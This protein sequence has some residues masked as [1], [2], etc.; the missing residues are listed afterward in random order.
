MKT[1]NSL[2]LAVI[3]GLFVT[4]CGSDDKGPDKTESTKT[5][6][7]V[8]RIP[9]QGIA[10][11]VISTPDTLYL[12][13]IMG[14]DNAPNFIS[15]EFQN[16]KSYLK[17]EGL[18]KAP[19]DTKIQNLQIKIGNNS[20]NPI[21]TFAVNPQGSEKA[22][23]IELTSDAEVNI[24]KAVLKELGDKEKVAINIT[25]TPTQTIT[26]ATTPVYLDLS[27]NAS[28]RYWVYDKN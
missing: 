2:L 16:S 15:S 13:A 25:F 23:E 6:N 18:D 27:I 20:Y 21:G 3:A 10:G 24:I 1:F 8:Y 19:A 11:S 9:I 4:A 26:L 12:S 14:A 17:V 28:F 22:S 7:N 5:F